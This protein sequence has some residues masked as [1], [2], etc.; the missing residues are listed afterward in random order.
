VCCQVNPQVGR[1]Y[2]ID[3][4]PAS[5]VKAVMVIGGGPG[6]MSTALAAAKKG[7]RVTLFEQS[8]QLGGKLPFIAAPMDRRKF[9]LFHKHLID[10][11]DK[12][13]IDVRLNCPISSDI[14]LA[15]NPDV[16]VIAT[17][18]TELKPN[19]P[20]ADLS[21]VHSALNVLMDWMAVGKEV[22]VIGGG[23]TGCETALFLAQKGT[24]SPEAL[25]Y[26]FVK[27][28]EDVDTLM[29]MA[30]RGTKKVTIMEMLPKIGRDIGAATRWTI[31]QDLKRFGVKVVSGATAKCIEKD[32]VT[33]VV[34]GV[35]QR[36]PC[37][38][39]VLAFGAVSHNPLEEALT[40]KIQNVYVI[41][42]AKKPR[43]ALDAVYEGYRVGNRL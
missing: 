21:H 12:Q 31:L 26:L 18:A 5:I 17:G 36:L 24:L 7:H 32:R 42:D 3:G 28:A 1:E 4:R 27:K 22:V 40:N 23:A 30:T 37:D 15:A 29:E 43:T 19:I 34:D 16:V 14:I 10:Q 38:S 13:D 6:G 41:G 11:V 35:E 8:D 9:S 25:H 2:K 33:V 39:V 20:G